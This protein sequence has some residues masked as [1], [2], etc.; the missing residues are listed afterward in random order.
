MRK[1]PFLPVLTFGTIA[2]L[3]P[4]CVLAQTPAKD[5]AAPPKLEKLEEGEPPTITIKP[6]SSKNR[7]TE[8]RGPGNELKEIKVKSGPST[9]ILRP[10]RATGN[11]PADDVV[12]PQWVVKEFNGK[13]PKEADDKAAP[14]RLEP[15]SSPSKSGNK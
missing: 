5:A 10:K 11:T 6:P 4:F 7:I 15:A 1:I 12:V 13:T 3:V 9:Y 14:Q 8:E 2:L